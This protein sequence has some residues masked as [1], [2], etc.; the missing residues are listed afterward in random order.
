MRAFLLSLLLLPGLLFGQ[1][2]TI[3]NPRLQDLQPTGGSPSGVA[4]LETNPAAAAGTQL[5]YVTGFA[6]TGSGAP[7]GMTAT[8]PPF[9]VDTSASALYF[10]DGTNWNISGGS[11]T[12]WE[13]SGTTLQPSVAG[14]HLGSAGNEVGDILAQYLQLGPDASNYWTH[15]VAADGALTMQGNGAGGSITISP[16]AGQNVTLN[17]GGGALFVNSTNPYRDIAANGGNSGIKFVDFGVRFTGNSYTRLS[18]SVGADPDAG[19]TVNTYIGIAPAASNNL[20]PDVYLRRDAANTLALRNG[21][22]PQAINVYNTYTDASNY[23]RGFF[24][25]NANVLEIGTEAAGTGTNRKIRI[26]GAG[27]GSSAVIEIAPGI[28]GVRWIFNNNGGEF[29]PNGD[30][31]FDIGLASKYVRSTY[32]E[33]IY[34]RPSASLTPANNGDVTIEATNDTT[35]TFKLKGS[36]GT[37]RSGTITLSE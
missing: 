18:T 1:D 17:V 5:S 24:K 30:G 8:V 10:H 35:L 15:T 28:A 26:Q 22:N 19:I 31:L 37:V 25:F 32:T 9:Y 27:T 4:L 7:D 20:S 29:Y 33:D 16:T 3:K 13:E 34:L 36:D 14:Y 2:P 6:T 12:N 23:E 21:V 11:L